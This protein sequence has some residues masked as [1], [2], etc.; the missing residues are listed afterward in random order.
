[1]RSR[2]NLS[3]GEKRA[4][5]AD[6]VGEPS[7]AT[8]CAQDGG[9]GVGSECAAWVCC[10]CLEGQAARVVLW[11]GLPGHQETTFMQ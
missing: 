2:E 10:V 6:F 3:S 1:M 11:H 5:C 9:D 7:G 8:F 4:G